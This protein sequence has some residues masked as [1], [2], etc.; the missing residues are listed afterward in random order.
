[1]STQANPSN[2]DVLA[3]IPWEETMAELAETLRARGRDIPAGATV[4]LERVPEDE[5]DAD[6]LPLYRVK[7]VRH[8]R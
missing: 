2:E 6:G 4:T 1:M 8:D 7:V 5:R 3:A